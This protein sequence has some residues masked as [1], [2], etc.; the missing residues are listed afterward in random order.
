MVYARLRASKAEKEAS[1]NLRIY[2]T[3]MR[4][5]YINSMSISC[6]CI[7]SVMPFIAFD[8]G[9]DDNLSRRQQKPIISNLASTLQQTSSEKNSYGSGSSPALSA[10]GMSVRQ[11]CSRT[12]YTLQQI[13]EASAEQPPT[14]VSQLSY[15]PYTPQGPP[16]PANL[17]RTFVR[18][19]QLVDQQ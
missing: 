12:N 9:D 16:L 4:Q 11:S 19:K 6:S 1:S 5:Y 14:P 2:L 3:H 17:Q 15:K 18:S 8:T 10:A 13:R 7:D